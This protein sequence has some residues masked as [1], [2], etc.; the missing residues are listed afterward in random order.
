MFGAPDKDK[1]KK[2]FQ[3][4]HAALALESEPSRDPVVRLIV[5][6]IRALAKAF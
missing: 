5:E 3:D 1:V 6:F 4:F 2:A